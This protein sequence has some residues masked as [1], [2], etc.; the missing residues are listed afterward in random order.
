MTVFFVVLISALVNTPCLAA[1]SENLPSKPTR[2]NGKAILSETHK[3]LEW[4]VEVSIHTSTRRGPLFAVRDEPRDARAA[5]FPYRWTIITN[6]IQRAQLVARGLNDVAGLFAVTVLIGVI[7][8]IIVLPR[9][10][11]VQPSIRVSAF[12]DH[13][14]IQY[15]QVS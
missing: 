13:L 9:I 2:D 8:E 5:R 1:I 10:R 15:L 6:A 4:P 14:R 7:H 11:F 12:A 3:L